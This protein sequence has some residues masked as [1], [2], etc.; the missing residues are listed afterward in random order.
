MVEER[1][2]PLRDTRRAKVGSLMEHGAPE[3]LLPV[4]RG[5]NNNTPHFQFISF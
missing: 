4:D 1:D 5:M 2:L 3:E